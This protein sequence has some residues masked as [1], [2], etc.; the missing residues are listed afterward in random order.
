MIKMSKEYYSSTIE[1]N[2]IKEEFNKNLHNKIK[3]FTNAM[4]KKFALDLFGTAPSFVW[5]HIHFFR[6]WLNN[7]NTD[8]ILKIVLQFLLENIKELPILS[9][10]R[11]VCSH[12]LWGNYAVNNPIIAEILWSVLWR[13]FSFSSNSATRPK[14]R[15]VFHSPRSSTWKLSSTEIRLIP[16]EFI[17]NDKVLIL[18]NRLQSMSSIPNK[19]VPTLYTELITYYKWLLWKKK[20]ASHEEVRNQSFM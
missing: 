15:P 6:S 7:V 17:L 13:E 19:D 16:T 1:F 20:S 4:I 10:E 18:I 2:F 11:I 14:Y 8:V 5:T 12:Q 3:R 9:I